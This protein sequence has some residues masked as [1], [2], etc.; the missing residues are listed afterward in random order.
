[1]IKKIRKK[2]NRLVNTRCFYASNINTILGLEFGGVV[3]CKPY[4]ILE[5][6]INNVG[7][8]EIVIWCQWRLDNKYD[9]LCSSYSNYEVIA[10]FV[11]QLIGDTV[12]EIKVSPPVWDTTIT[13]L[14]GK[15]LKI[16]CN[17][18]QDADVLTNWDLGIMDMYYGMGRGKKLQ[19]GK[20]LGILPDAHIE[21]S[22]IVPNIPTLTPR[23]F[24]IDQSSPETT[25]TLLIVLDELHEQLKRLLGKR[26]W[27]VYNRSDDSLILRL[28][29]A[30]RR[31]CS[32]KERARTNREFQY[33]GEYEIIVW[34][35]WRLE[36][37]KDGICSSDSTNE[38]RDAGTQQLVGQTVV[39]IEILSPAW[40]A[41]ITFSSGE[42]L[43][44][45]CIY[46]QDNEIETNWFFRN[47]ETLYC[48]NRSKNIEKTI[49]E[50]EIQNGIIE[51][52]SEIS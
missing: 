41:V 29:G 15:T 30:I 10:M 19:E 39:S 11:N 21:C 14:S 31:V 2:L 22:V 28:G 36:N 37:S 43:K 26:C 24:N 46:T 27:A 18:I 32:E 16:F 13:F 20:R 48:M 52:P 47:V 6:G 35:A 25:N 5:K 12:V 23:D 4:D 34:S 7:Q 51:P 33:A 38:Q 45:F 17:Y 9:T 1:M 49:M 3:L 50:W 44:I 42:V 40:D 8:Y